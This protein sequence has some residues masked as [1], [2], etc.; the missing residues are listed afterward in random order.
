MTAK[1]LPLGVIEPFPWGTQPIPVSGTGSSDTAVIDEAV[2]KAMREYGIVGTGV[3]VTRNEEIVYSR[4]FGYAELPCTPFLESTA[5]RCGS[6]AKPVTALCAMLLVDRGKLD[7]DAPILSLLKEGGIVPRSVGTAQMDERI[8]EIR[9]RHLMDHTSGL[10]QSAT[11]TAWREERNVAALHALDHPATGADVVADALGNTRLAS[12]PGTQYQYANANFVLLAR[13]IEVC[14]GMRFND[15]LIRVAMACFGVAPEEIYVSRNQ[16]RPW[17]AERGANEAA[18][19]QTSQECYVSYLPTEQSK[20]RTFGEAYHGYAT[21]A[22]DGAGGIACT[23]RGVGKILANLHST[24]PALS[25]SAMGEIL[26]PPDLYAQQPGFD[27]AL[28][29]FYSKGFNI[30]FS[31]G[32]PYYSHGGMTNHCGG[33]IGHNAGYQFVAVSNWNHS[34]PP[35]VDSILGLPLAEVVARR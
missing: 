6:L 26:T 24:N 25:P 9:V 28:S 8:E 7:L 3:C 13:I 10:P 22:S 16:D 29:N 4:G 11:Y 18:Y 23:A 31:G 32:R 1:N 33:V 17:S 34:Q 30:C 35:Y 14:S 12:V 5:S 2:M 27:A 19:Y 21:E 20:G 15:F